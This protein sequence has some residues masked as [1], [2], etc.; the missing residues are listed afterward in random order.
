MQREPFQN[1][2]KLY[3]SKRE[4]T[5]EGSIVGD[6]KKQEDPSFRCEILLD[7]SQVFRAGEVD[8]TTVRYPDK[9]IIYLSAGM[10]YALQKNGN[11]SRHELYHELGHIH[12][13]HYDSGLVFDGEHTTE[14][15]ARI[16]KEE[17]DADRFAAEIIGYD[18]SINAL[19]EMLRIRARADKMENRNGT[20]QSVLAI[21]EIRRRIKALEQAAEDTGS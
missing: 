17:D 4:D 2:Y 3:L 8:I 7:S 18:N 21:R 12:L 11:I 9:Y 13:G 5:P 20:E 14:D 6:F 15:A 16:Q 10:L 1:P 19:R